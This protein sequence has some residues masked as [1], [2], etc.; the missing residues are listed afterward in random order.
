MDESRGRN[1]QV[2]PFPEEHL[3]PLPQLQN[4]VTVNLQLTPGRA[5][6]KP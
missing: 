4:V 2:L 1:A 5:F 3:L 6:R